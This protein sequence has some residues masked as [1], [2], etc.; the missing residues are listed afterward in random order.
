MSDSNSNHSSESLVH[1]KPQEFIEQHLS[2]SVSG[3]IH[4][5][6]IA[7]VQDQFIKE[8]NKRNTNQIT[9]NLLLPNYDVRKNKSTPDLRDIDTAGNLI[10]PGKFRRHHV[11]SNE[12][13]TN[14][15]MGN[16]LTPSTL[17][18]I[19]LYGN[20]AGGYYFEESNSETDEERPLLGSP[21]QHMQQRIVGASTKKTYFLLM[22]SFIGTGILFLPRAFLSGG[23]IFSTISLLVV[24][25]LTNWG[26][27]LLIEVTQK[28]PNKS[29][30][31][32]AE[33]LYGPKAKA[34]VLMSI[35]VSQLGFCIAYFVFCSHNMKDAIALWTNCSVQLDETWLIFAQ[36]LFYIPL[37]LV[38][39]IHYFS[40]S[41]IIADILI[42]I[43][44]A[45]VLSGDFDQFANLP[46]VQYINS[47]D[48]IALFLGTA[49]YTF[50]G[51]GLIVP[52]SQSMAEPN[53]MPKVLS[54]CMITVSIIYT[55]VGAASYTAFGDATQTVVLLNL[56]STPILALI[57]MS[58]VLAIILS[59][60]L[61]LF[62][63]LRI[64]EQGIFPPEVYNGKHNIWHKWQKN[65]FRIGVVSILSYMAWAGQSQLELLVTFIG[66]FACIPLSFCWPSFLHYKAIATTKS[67][68]IKDILLFLF[69]LSGMLVVCGIAFQ[70]WM[71]GVED[72]PLNRCK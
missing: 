43:G 28:L 8:L 64:L 7:D 69:G 20:F 42:L 68:K 6:H 67:Q 32:I 58:Y 63:A 13:D 35:I 30:G 60:P 33:A 57:Q 54:L 15:T 11:N 5:S 3:T 59:W 46:P 9:P 48:K 52:I 66:A 53:K 70:K 23:L 31:D 56:P 65:I 50:E 61:Q 16:T 18:F 38:R 27:L 36:I 25:F 10:G 22:K 2:S 17:D 37:S 24:A 21:S 12:F 29:F 19:L 47:P 55:V 14:N 40:Y 51:V 41:S 45:Y 49:V 71:D 62:P 72:V 1:G 44:V 4:S 26:M 39:R 34:V